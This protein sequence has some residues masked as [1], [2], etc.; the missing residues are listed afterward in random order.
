[1]AADVDVFKADQAVAAMQNRIGGLTAQS[2]G[3]VVDAFM[4]PPADTALR[5]HQPRQRLLRLAPGP[6]GR[7]LPPQPAERALALKRGRLVA[8]ALPAPAARVR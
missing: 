1:M 6:R 7:I 3:V 4:N 2:D 5:H 8:P